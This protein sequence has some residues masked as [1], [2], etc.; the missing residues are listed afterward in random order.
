MA[1]CF[2]PEVTKGQPDYNAINEKSHNQGKHIS[3][4]HSF[5]PRS[6]CS[7]LERILGSYGYFCAT[8]AWEAICTIVTVTLCVV[9]SSLVRIVAEDSESAAKDPVQEEVRKSAYFE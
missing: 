8:H 9:S 7:W 2:E 6:V 1:D 5:V 3:K 4:Y